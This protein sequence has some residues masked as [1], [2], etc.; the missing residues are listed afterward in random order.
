MDEYTKQLIEGTRATYHDVVAGKGS[1]IQ[2]GMILWD[3]FERAA[4]ACRADAK[5][6]ERQLAERINE[7]AMA[8]VLADDK[9]LRGPLTYEP[10][11]LPSGRRIDF[12]ADRLRDNIYIEVK[13]VHPETADTEAAW[14]NYVK[15]RKLHPANADFVVHKDWMGGK[16]YGNTFTSRSHFLEYTMDF[17]SRLAEV[18]KVKDGPGLLVFCGKG[19]AGIARIWRTSRTTIMRG[20]T[21]RTTPS[22]DGK[23]SHRNGVAPASAQRGQLRLRPTTHRAGPDSRFLL[24]CAGPKLWR[25]D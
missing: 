4:D 10:N 16:L 1:R 19:P 15:R 11:L 6:S 21:A 3:L 17:E 7:L 9:G 2:R 13:T 14:D 20:S 22:L 23:A 8:K 24:A 25:C 5:G 18:K 12:V